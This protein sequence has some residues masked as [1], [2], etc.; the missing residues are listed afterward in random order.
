MAL[1]DTL[2]A[3]LREYDSAKLTRFVGNPLAAFIRNEAVLDVERAAGPAARGLSFAGSAGAGNW[4]ETPWLAAFDPVVTDGASR[5]YYVI[6]VFHVSDSI[7]HLSLNQGASAVRDEF[8]ATAR[9]VL[10]ERAAFIRVRLPDFVL[11]LS[12]THIAL[13]STAP[14]SGDYAAGHALGLTYSL[15]NLPDEQTLADDLRSALQAYRALT[16]RGGLDTQPEKEVGGEFEQ[17]QSLT[18]LRQLRL[19]CL[20]ER[21]LIAANA[22]KQHHGSRCQACDVDLGELYG[23]IGRGY[24]EAH[25]LRPISTLEEGVIVRYDVAAEFAVLCPNCHRMIHRMEDPSNLYKLRALLH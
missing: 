11:R 1:R 17:P 4:A 18:E 22:A 23:P 13:E 9:Q 19:H 2:E 25:H 15:G 20:I 10:S 21:S 6:Y 14:L 8:G 24:I 7:V 16:F 5:G 3:V 12:T